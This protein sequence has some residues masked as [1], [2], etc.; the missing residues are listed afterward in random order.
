MTAHTPDLAPDTRRLMPGVDVLAELPLLMAARD[1]ARGL[2]TGGFVTGYRGSPLA[3][4]DR[5]AEARAAAYA[6]AGVVFRP[7]LNEDLAATTVWG[8]QQTGLI[9]RPDV[10]GVFALWYGK[11]PGVDRS[12]DALRHA[13]TAGAAR[14][15]IALRKPGLVRP[16]DLEGMAAFAARC[17]ALLVVEEKRPLIED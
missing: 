14:A 2:R 13:D 8:T 4:F 1:T 7:G 9:P 15:G 16:L 3:Q 17:E 6:A 12:L 10:E 5:A 11:R